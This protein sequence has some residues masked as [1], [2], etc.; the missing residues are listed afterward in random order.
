[1]CCI[2]RSQQHIRTTFLKVLPPFSFARLCLF[3]WVLINW[4]RESRDEGHESV[5]LRSGQ[6]TPFLLTRC[7]CF[8]IYK[9]DIHVQLCMFVCES[10]SKYIPWCVWRSEAIFKCQPNL[11][12]Y[13]KRDFI[14]VQDSWPWSFQEISCLCFPS[15]CKSTGITEAGLQSW[16]TR[17]FNLKSVCLYSKLVIHWL[18]VHSMLSLFWFY[19]L[20]PNCKILSS[21]LSSFPSPPFK[22]C[23][24]LEVNGHFQQGEEKL[25][26]SVLHMSY[27]LCSH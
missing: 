15:L 17:E 4:V 19:F 20:P 3:L 7:Q 13:L 16:F 26:K 5:L 23:I 27:V 25:P 6:I 1:V 24:C 14:S 22:D 8:S 18:I 21:F 9:D 12:P 10:V 2:A 11:P